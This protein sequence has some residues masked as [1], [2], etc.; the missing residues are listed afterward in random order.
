MSPEMSASHAPAAPALS[1]GGATPSL[2]MASCH[3]PSTPAALVGHAT[4]EG[5]TMG[6]LPGGVATETKVAK[7]A[8]NEAHPQNDFGHNAPSRSIAPKVENQVAP[9]ADAKTAAPEAPKAP[10]AE[11]AKEPERGG[12]MGALDTVKDFVAEHPVIA[13]IAAAAAIYALQSSFGAGGGSIL[14][15]GLIGTA[16]ALVGGMMTSKADKEKEKKGEFNLGITD[17]ILPVKGLYKIGKTLMDKFSL[18]KA[19]GPGVDA[20]GSGAADGAQKLLDAV[21]TPAA[22]GPAKT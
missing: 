12:V 11:P 1:Q 17:A 13:S 3:T 9:A 18:A 22:G 19:S 7:M 4:Q 14:T 10:A 6:Q 5:A 20:A 2:D 21:K 16:T 15:A 8:C